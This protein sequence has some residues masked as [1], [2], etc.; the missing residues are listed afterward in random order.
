[1]AAPDE[2]TAA[3]LA[4]WR[5]EAPG[6]EQAAH[7]AHELRTHLARA[8]AGDGSSGA[9]ALVEDSSG[10]DA[11]Q[12]R[13][14]AALVE[15]RGHGVR[16]LLD[17][18]AWLLEQLGFAWVEPGEQ[19]VCF[20]PGWALAQGTCRESPRFRRRTLIL[21]QDALHDDWRDWLEWASRNRL[22]GLFLHD[23]P[24]SREREPGTPRPV[25]SAGF[26]RDRGGWLFERWQADG[27]LIV[28]AA[29]A[30][31]MT[32][33]FGGHHMTTLLPRALSAEHPDWFPQRDGHRDARHNLCVSSGALEY[34]RRAAERFVERYPGADVYH[35]WADD[36]VGGGWCDCAGCASMGPAEQALVATNAIAAGVARVAPRAQVAHLAYHDTLTPTGAVAPAGNVTLLWAP[37]ERC[38]AHGLGDS[39]CARNRDEYR[40]PLEALLGDPG[41]AGRTAQA[42]E[43]WSDAILFKGIAAPHLGVLPADMAHY[44]SAGVEDVQDLAVGDRPW[45]G[46]P[47]HAWWFGRCAWGAEDAG[48]AL[49]RFAAAAYGAESAEAAARYYERQ[50]AACRALVD[51]RDFG[52]LPGFDVLDFATASPATLAAKAEEALWAAGELETCLVALDSVQSASPAAVARRDRERDQAL[53]N[54][55]SARHLASRLAARAAAAGGDRMGAARQAAAARDAL[56]ELERWDARFDVPAYGAVRAFMR[57]SAR[58]HTERIAKEIDG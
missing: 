7:A 40:A 18:T 55:L 8:G 41:W 49:R 15:V 28:E 37:R 19:G 54:A 34:L 26:V 22:N 47:W 4:G 51:R 48:Q 27:P 46:P 2:V 57:H 10:G 30:R 21:G 5:I 17:G 53:A 31:G 33:Q 3:R 25:D 52:D 16:G 58:S 12:V 20:Q 45:V 50:D 13:V 24:P 11:F 36:I 39:A 1:M 42:F 9:V 56:A 23:T 43:Y 44:E 38:Y 32:V 29:K 14:E 35:L 6:S